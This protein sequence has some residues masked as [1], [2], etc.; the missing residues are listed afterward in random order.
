MQLGKPCPPVKNA[1]QTIWEQR[2]A[3]SNPAAPTKNQGL[4]PDKGL[5]PFFPSPRG[6]PKGKPFPSPSWWAGARCRSFARLSPV[7]LPVLAR[8]ARQGARFHFLLP[9]W[10]L[11]GFSSRAAC[12]SL[13][14]IAGARRR[15][16]MRSRGDRVAV[17]AGG[18]GP[19]AP[20]PRLQQPVQVSP[21]SGK[22]AMP[23]DPLRS[24]S[25]PGR[26][27]QRRV[28]VPGD[29]FGGPWPPASSSTTNS[30][31]PKRDSTSELRSAPVMRS[32]AIF[33]IWS[34]VPWP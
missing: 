2:V 7:L 32:A 29:L 4:S 20:C 3:S 1:T 17:A 22:T 23:M 14:G 12:A 21:S 26:G 28:Q 10:G 31:P 33:R 18:L 15:R 27:G 5:S 19:V 9:P 24:T 16:P 34:P 13:A 11:R 25:T 6:K 30:S 8:R